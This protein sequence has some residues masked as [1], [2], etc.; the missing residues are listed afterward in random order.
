MSLLEPPTVHTSREARELLGKTVDSF[1]VSDNAQP[2]IFGSHRKP[3]AV[4]IPYGLYRD[5]LPLLEDL[6]IART[7]RARID[8]GDSEPL[9][10]V[11]AR[12]GL[13]VPGE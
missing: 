12:L 6:E 5:M 4:V 7:A 2:L 10:D 1:R 11:A 9:A 8:A 3:E 13:Q